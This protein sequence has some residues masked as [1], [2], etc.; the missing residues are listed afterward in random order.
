VGTV[1]VTGGAGFIGS[2]L[3]DALL[4]AGHEVHIVDNLSTGSR[5][6]L[7]A[8]AVF[9]ELDIREA[10]ALGA[11]VE[12]IRP[13]TVFHLA[14]QADVRKAVE[15]PD[16]DAAINVIG[17]INVLEAA[18]RVDARVVFTSTGGAAYGEYPGLPIPT[19]E[20]ADARPMSQYGAGKMA[21]EGYCLLYHRLYGLG[22]VVLRL[23][24][25]YGPRQDPHGEAG[26]VSIFAGRLL[27]GVAPRVFGDGTQT[28]DYVFVGD[29]L[30]AFLAAQT[31]GDGEIVNIGCG[32]EIS[33]LDLLDA[34]DAPL[35]PEF[36]PARTGELQRSALAN[37]RAREV[38]GWTPAVPLAEGL[39][40]TREAI[41]VTHGDPDAPPP[42]VM[43][44][45]GA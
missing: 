8:A 27:D 28:R 40:M 7:P 20:T 12:S 45:M 9:H 19:P 3:A 38:L 33:V 4:V 32:E 1:V 34:F 18:R 24:N 6:K 30:R 29:V 36:A 31:T 44:M 37:A 15:H 17:T 42:G 23:G 35:E 14:A 13:E 25:V 5:K 26:V 16:L 2:N 21:G 39:R 41:A 10:A 43:Q 22:V 11:L